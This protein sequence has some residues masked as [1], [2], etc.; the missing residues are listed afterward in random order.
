MYRDADP[1]LE[2][3]KT[4]APPEA[5]QHWPRAV[6]R[7]RFDEFDSL[8]RI[9]RGGCGEVSRTL[10]RPLDVQCALK[11]MRLDRTD[12]FFLEEVEREVERQKRVACP[13]VVDVFGCGQS[14]DGPFIAYELCEGGTLAELTERGDVPQSVR[15]RL[16]REVAQGMAYMH[17][18]GVI[19]SNLKPRAIML[20]GDQ[21]A[22]IGSFSMSTELPPGRDDT[23]VLGYTPLYASPETLSE[24]RV[25]RASDVFSFGVLGCVV[26]VDPELESKVHARF[27]SMPRM[28]MACADGSIVREILL[29]ALAASERGPTPLAPAVVGLLTRCLDLDAHQRP[30]FE[31]LLR[32]IA[33]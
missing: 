18:F 26:L 13:W 4:D 19:H 5:P 33:C 10:F 2:S 8:S 9:G 15:L 29:P 25:S 22:K 12:A 32:G 1:D 14:P 30:H 24:N 6:L 31:E 7:L 11:Q 23:D 17:R 21:H 20:T 16:L 28:T 3:G 27:P